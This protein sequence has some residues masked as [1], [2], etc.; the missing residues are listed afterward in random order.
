MSGYDIIGDIHGNPYEP[1]IASN[2]CM[3]HVK[4]GTSR[5]PIPNGRP[6]HEPRCHTCRDHQR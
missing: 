4:S 1:S 3:V 2:T 5:E 6:A